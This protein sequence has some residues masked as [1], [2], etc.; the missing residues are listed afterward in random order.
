MIRFYGPGAY[1]PGPHD[2]FRGNPE[3]PPAA[4]LDSFLKEA[5]ELLKGVETVGFGTPFYDQCRRTG[6]TGSAA[7]R[8]LSEPFT[9]TWRF[10]NEQ[11][12]LGKAT[13]SFESIPREPSSSGTRMPLVSFGERDFLT[14]CPI[15]HRIALKWEAG[16][17]F[18]TQILFNGL[19][20]ISG[21]KTAQFSNLLRQVLFENLIFIDGDQG[22]TIQGWRDQKTQEHKARP[23]LPYLSYESVDACV[24]GIFEVYGYQLSPEGWVDYERGFFET[25]LADLKFLKSSPDFSAISKWYDSCQS[26]TYSPPT[27][28]TPEPLLKRSNER[29]LSGQDIRNK[30]QEIATVEGSLLQLLGVDPAALFNGPMLRG[31]APMVNQVYPAPPWEK[32]GREALW[33]KNDESARVYVVS[34]ETF[35]K[36]AGVVRAGSNSPT[37]MT[38]P[39]RIRPAPVRS[40]PPPTPPSTPIGFS[41]W[42]SAGPN[43]FSPSPYA[44]TDD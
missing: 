39:D 36:W 21:Q 7:L 24:M 3:Q 22:I 42:G 4:L 28:Y 16:F 9:P 40:S 13:L 23:F 31:G 38:E 26:R 43:I 34:P 18:C 19:N 32:I 30:L 10:R 44:L 37:S 20:V 29:V 27:S 6:L 25:L 11:L 41:P 15:N 1:F 8:R 14:T 35:N 17:P 12:Q 2:V 5:P 33:R